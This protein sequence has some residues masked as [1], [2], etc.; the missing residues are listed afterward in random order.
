MTHPLLTSAVFT[1]VLAAAGQAKAAT[2]EAK[3]PELGHVQAAIASA[4][5]GDTVLVPAGT[6]SWNATLVI[7]KGITLQGATS[8]DGSLSSPVVSDKTVILDDIPRPRR[9]NPS[10]EQQQGSPQ[11][12][13][14]FPPGA[15]SFRG[16][17]R[18]PSKSNAAAGP[19]TGHMPAIIVARLKATQSFRLTGFTFKYGSSTTFA[20]NGGVH[21]VGTCPSARIDHCH[22]DQLYANPFIMTRG[23]IYGV[24]D[25][26][27][28]DERGRALTFQ[29]Y[30]DGW[31]GH[32]HGD[33]SWA[34]PSYFG[35][36]KFLFIEDNTFRNAKGYKSNG[37]DS[38]G[39][40]RYVARRNYL[41]DTPI[42]GHGTETSGR[43]RG[44]RA[45]EVYNNTYVWNLVDPRGQL[46]SG[47]MLAFNNVFTGKIKPDSKSTH[48]TCYRQFRPFPFWGGAN[49]NNRLDSNDSHGLYASGKHTGGNGSATLVVANAGWRENQ[50]VGYSVTNTT[51]TVKGRT[52]AIFHP[53]SCIKTNTSDTITFRASDMGR[54]MTFNNGDGY[55]IYKLI[56]ALDQPGR[57]KGDLLADKDPVMTGSWP[58][59][60]LEPVYAWGN[61]YNNLQQ[62]DVGSRYPTIQEN[63][64]FYNQKTPFDGTVGVGVG[65]IADRPKTCAQGVAYWATD[66][67]DWDST[68]DGPDGQ[69]YVCTAPNTWTLYYK[70]YTYPHPLVSGVPASPGKVAEV[71]GK[72]TDATSSSNK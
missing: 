13:R 67:G 22:F 8:I 46:R 32:A 45:I 21:L 14:A 7:T 68:H 37:I 1:F 26:C 33:G 27:V 18:A 70:P 10:M 28:L 55:A 66:Q 5:E 52:G 58:H 53:S 30:H 54:P 61:T 50:W 43:F 23:Q 39:G 6:A 38:Y 29:V 63:R 12:P 71:R 40:G 19:E 11:Q 25:H 65:K 44:V 35:S 2:V 69:L 24:V 3:S 41:V 64:D 4:R 72:A 42:G 34:D 49:G 20:D 36:E 56:A 60:A 51:Q 17:A 48:L 15:G 62:L 31:G 59:Q 57:G 47:T 9:R 16:K